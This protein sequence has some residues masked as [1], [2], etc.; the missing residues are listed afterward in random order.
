MGVDYYRVLGVARDSTEKQIKQGYKELALANNPHRRIVKPPLTPSYQAKAQLEREKAQ[1]DES[2]KLF[3][4]A[5]E[6]YDVLNDPLRRAIFDRYGDTG[7]KHGIRA[8]EGFIEPYSYHCDPERTFR[9]FFRMDFP[10]I[11]L[12]T[13]GSIPLDAFVCARVNGIR[14][15]NTT[16]KRDLW[17]TFEELYFGCIK[18][19]MIC[20]KLLQPD[21]KSTYVENKV[22]SVT[23]DRGSLGGQ[24][25]T[26]PN[27]GDQDANFEPADVIF[28]F[29][30]VPHD[31]FQRDG[32]D[33][34][35][36]ADVTLG[37]ALTG[38]SVTIRTL[39]N[40]TFRVGIVYVVQPGYEKIVPKE[41]FP[42]LGQPSIKG[43]LIIRFNILFPKSLIAS[44][45][46]E[47]KKAFN[48]KFPTG[49]DCYETAPPLHYQITHPE[50]KKREVI[51]NSHQD[52]PED[53]FD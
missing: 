6:A 26:F 10:F 31:R 33:L 30:E 17:L 4:L 13:A 45:K 43:N 50:C 51:I 3:R 32:A 12:V 9:E 24:M 1:A 36:T 22:L 48:K 52:T 16:V 42:I 38:T 7:L 20:K 39:D 19:I 2:M 40:R 44:E 11:D 35:Y 49:L 27:E 53:N 28:V 23:V 18:K 8:T 41:G 15:K 46:A 25:V 37:E 47:I 21:G 34:I 5:A 14:P 29:R